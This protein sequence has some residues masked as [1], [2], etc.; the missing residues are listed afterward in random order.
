MG[1]DRGS[2]WVQFGTP[3]V[4]AVS[5]LVCA[6]Q[7]THD[8]R[9]Y[10]AALLL[11]LPLGVVAVVGVYVVY[12][13]LVQLVGLLSSGLSTDQVSDRTFLISGPINVLLFGA[14]AIANVL[15]LRGIVRGR[16]P[17]PVR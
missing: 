2:R 14:A 3:Y 5:G 1:V 16:H 7:V 10:L 15:L 11:T 13:L 17:K 6:A 8:G 12:G 4:L 9:F